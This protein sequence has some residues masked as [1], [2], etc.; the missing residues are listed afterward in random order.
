MATRT[1]TSIFSTMRKR[2]NASNYFSG[3]EAEPF[4]TTALA[5]TSTNT[6]TNA[7]DMQ[8]N[9]RNGT[10]TAPNQITRKL[11]VA[12]TSTKRRRR[13]WKFV[14]ISF[15]AI[16]FV[17]NILALILAC[18]KNG[19][20]YKN[21]INGRMEILSPEEIASNKSKYKD[22]VVSKEKNYAVVI[23]TFKRP[24]MLKSALNHW[25]N[26][27]GVDAG[28]SQVFVVW[29]ELDVKPPEPDDILSKFKATNNV[30]ISKNKSKQANTTS[31]A[32]ASTSTSTLTPSVKFIRVPKDSLNSRFLP[33]ENL[34]S[35]AVFMVDD[36]VKIDCDS[37]KSGFEAWRHSPDALVGFYPRFAAPKRGPFQS[38]SKAAMI[39]HTWPI[40][41][42]T[43]TFNIILTK[44]CFFDRKYLT[45]YH[46][47][48]ENPKEILDYIDENK[49]CED[50]AMAFLV[51]RKTG[52]PSL[53]KDS[54]Y[55]PE[56]PVYTKGKITDEGLFNGISTS[57]GKLAPQGHMEKRSL[58]LDELTRIY[59][60]RNWE[61][62]LFDVDLSEQS[63]KH[64]LWTINAP[65][66]VLEWFSV[67][68]TLL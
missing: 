51:A 68:N 32:S 49:N 50:I 27:C 61:F 44:A 38:K 13:I 4:V 56:C 36:D 64:I 59:K 26:V 5:S 33:I 35:K 22:I 60:T 58:C 65:S 67:G 48:N 2:I 12:R 57:G 28:I 8:H 66:N 15:L 63:W 19:V 20:A 17:Y 45:M 18:S 16:F 37:M 47:D 31:L 46:D 40:V 43:Q 3:E 42:A 6:N 23:N 29:A 39:Y 7:H 1:G 52:H 54:G 14:K 53:N 62:P 11:K 10:G 34:N 25:V 30:R 21:E 24:E 41:Y 9:Q 55:C